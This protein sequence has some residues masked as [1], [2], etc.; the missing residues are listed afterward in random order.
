MPSSE[1]LASLPPG[2]I[3][4]RD[5]NGQP[6]EGVQVSAATPV[7]KNGV[8]S[9]LFIGG[10]GIGTFLMANSMHDVKHTP[11]ASEKS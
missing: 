4:L 10:A 5:E 8:R 6:V 2:T 1:D 9:L 3:E 11:A 7:T